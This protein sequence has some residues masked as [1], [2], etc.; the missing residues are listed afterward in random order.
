LKKNESEH[1]IDPEQKDENRGF[2]T[3]IRDA[4]NRSMFG[5]ESMANSPTKDAG[6]FESP[7]ESEV[8][9]IE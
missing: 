2:F 8:T 4:I 1:Q 6:Q 7:K 5:G 3:S 9:V